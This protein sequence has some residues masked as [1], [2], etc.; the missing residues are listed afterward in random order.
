[1]RDVSMKCSRRWHSST[2]MVSS[3]RFHS[4]VARRTW[5]TDH[6]SRQGRRLR[7]FFPVHSIQSTPSLELATIEQSNQKLT[8]NTIIHIGRRIDVDHVFDPAV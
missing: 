4:E 3:L 2:V 5:S 8:V 1:M 7:S 6:A